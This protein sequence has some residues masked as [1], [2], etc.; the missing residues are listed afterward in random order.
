LQKIYTQTAAP[1]AFDKTF[2]LCAQ[3]NFPSRVSYFGHIATLLAQLPTNL[4]QFYHPESR[5]PGL[6]GNNS[7]HLAIVNGVST[8]FRRE[9]L[10]TS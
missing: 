2:E 7:I 10:D 6:F 1:S 9:K 3:N 4:V 5:Y 8:S